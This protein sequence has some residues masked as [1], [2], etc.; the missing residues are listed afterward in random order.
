MPLSE[1]GAWWKQL[2]EDTKAKDQAAKQ[3]Q[4]KKDPD[5]PS[6]PLATPQVPLGCET[7]VVV[8]SRS[9]GKHQFIV[10]LARTLAIAGYG[11]WYDQLNELA[12]HQWREHTY[13]R[14]KLDLEPHGVALLPPIQLVQA[15]PC[16][17][18][19]GAEYLSNTEDVT[20]LNLIV[21]SVP[22]M[23]TRFIRSAAGIP[24][25]VSEIKADDIVARITQRELDGWVG[26]PACMRTLREPNVSDST[27]R[28][29]YETIDPATIINAGYNAN[30]DSDRRV[31]DGRIN[32]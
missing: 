32:K 19:I 25:T 29:F 31:F 10:D 15:L 8:L 27:K 12:E 17:V 20:F 1:F 26:L 13:Y 3:R 23:R 18:W 6:N 30:M 5:E 11:S 21:Q 7:L 24:M 4:E 28:I 9:I 2:K 14:G 16:D 22:D